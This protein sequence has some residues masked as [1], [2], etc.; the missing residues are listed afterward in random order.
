MRKSSLSP[1][2]MDLTVIEI[3]SRQQDRNLLHLLNAYSYLN[4]LSQVQIDKNI[5]K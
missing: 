3:L 1:H 4:A 5:K 2:S